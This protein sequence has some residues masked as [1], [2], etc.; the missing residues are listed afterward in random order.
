VVR[1][2]HVDDEEDQLTITERNLKKFDPEIQ[3]ISVKSPK[4]A[5]KILQKEAIDCVV[6]DFKMPHMDGI[7]LA[8]KIKE[9][10]NIPII[11]YTGHGSEVVASKA[12]ASGIDDYLRK[13]FEISHIHVLAKR[14]RMNIERYKLNEKLKESEIKFRGIAERSIDIIY[15]LDKEGN[16][17]Y[18]SPVVEKIGGYKPQEIIGTSFKKYI[19][20]GLFKAIQARI[21]TM[22]GLDIK[23]LKIELL[24]KDG[25]HLPAEINAAPIISNGKAIGSQGIIRDITERVKAEQDLRESEEKFRNLAE[26][27]PNMIFINKK[28]RV[29]YTNKRCEEVMGYTREEFYSSDFNFLSLIAPEYLDSIKENFDNHMKSRDVDPLYYELLTKEG[30]RIDALLLSKLIPFEG[31]DAILGIVIDMTERKQLEEKL[32]NFARDAVTSIPDMNAT[33]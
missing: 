20:V 22:R 1:I 32:N 30:K 11:I 13:E 19:G 17:T 14:I 5:L 6:L 8:L 29:V 7:E 15:Q 12:F 10:K 4:E 9:R 2:L 26:Y 18:I 24:K 28:G 31:E 33:E 27:S 25:S 16:V 23:G 21:R 3:T